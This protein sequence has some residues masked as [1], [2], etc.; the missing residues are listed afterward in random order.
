MAGAPLLSLQRQPKRGTE[1]QT[2][3][4]QTHFETIHLGSICQPLTI[5]RENVG[6][7]VHTHILYIY[8]WISK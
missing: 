3:L 5:V 2:R 7:H 6:M 8:T 1:P 4:G